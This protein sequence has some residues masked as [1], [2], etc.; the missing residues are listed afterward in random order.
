MLGP[1]C[2]ALQL[3]KMQ[4]QVQS[5]ASRQA[6]ACHV[7]PVFRAVPQLRKQVTTNA[8]KEVFMPALS[9]TMTGET[10]PSADLFKG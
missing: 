8:V 6:V 9:S 3:S 4:T 2:D 1:E 10:L 5:A 7:K